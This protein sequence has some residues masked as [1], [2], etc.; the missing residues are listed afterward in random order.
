[1]DALPGQPLAAKISFAA[2]KSQFTSKDVE[3]HDERQKLVFRVKLRLTAL[4]AAPHNP[5]APRPGFS[6]RR[7][8]VVAVREGKELLR[9][10][11]RLAFAA[12]D[13]DNSA[14]RRSYLEAFRSSRYFEERAPV[15]SPQEL[16]RRL[17]ARKLKS[18]W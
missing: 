9:D 8:S 6:L 10:P 5:A 4:A 16:H 2:A 1:L 11:L 14:Q 15:S 17:H 7:L 18:C 13:Q 3:T 12:F